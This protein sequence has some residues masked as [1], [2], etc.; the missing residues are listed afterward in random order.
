MADPWLWDVCVLCKQH[1]RTTDMHNIKNIS[2]KSSGK[3]ACDD[4]YEIDCS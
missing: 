1:F 2:N 4:C 3:K